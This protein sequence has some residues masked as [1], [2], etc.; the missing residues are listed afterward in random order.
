M[1]IING[2]E[3]H[4]DLFMANGRGSGWHGELRAVKCIHGTA[5]GRCALD[6]GQSDS[7]QAAA[8]APE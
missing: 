2:L 5:G 4:Q 8:S 7:L 1:Q 6:R 3:T